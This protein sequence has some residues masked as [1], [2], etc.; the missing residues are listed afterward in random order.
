MNGSHPTHSTGRRAVHSSVALHRRPHLTATRAA[1]AAVLAALLAVVGMAG[2]MPASAAAAATVVP[3]VTS[4]SATPDAPEGGSELQPVVVVMDYSSSM[5]QADADEDGTTR[6]EAAEAATL[7]LIDK[8]PDGADLGVVVY[9]ANTVEDCVDIETVQSVAPLKKGDLKKKIEALNAVGET[10]I[11][12]SLLHAADELKDH[13]GEKSIILVSDGEENCSQPPACEAAQD[14]AD[15]GIDLTVHTI[16]FKVNDQARDELTCVAE[17]TGGTY[18]QAENAEELESRLE[19]K[20]VRAFQGYVPQGTPV[21]GGETLHASPQLA[22][23]QYL[24]EYEKGGSKIHAD[25]GT[26]KFY[27]LG[28]IQPGERAHFSA[29]LI[30]DQSA[31]AERGASY[32]GLKVELVNGQGVSCSSID[33]AYRGDDDGGRPIAGYVRSKDYAQESSDRCYSDGSGQLYAKVMRTS[34]RQSDLALP[35]ELK[36]VLEPAVD[37]STLDTPASEAEPVQSVTLSD[38]PQ[39]IAGGG[40]FN[41]ATEVDSGTVLTDSTMPMESRYYRI[42]VGYGQRL[43]VRASQANVDDAGPDGIHVD[44]YSA[45]RSPVRTVGDDL[46]YRS[47]TGETATQSMRVPVSQSNRDGSVG[48]D[49]YLAGDYYVVVSARKWT[50]DRNREPYPYDLA[51]E[52]TGEEQ[53]GPMVADPGLGQNPST[54]QDGQETQSPDDGT[55]QSAQPTESA[56]QESEAPVA[57]AGGDDAAAPGDGEPQAASSVRDSAPLPW[58]L[59]GLAGSALLGGV[60]VALL[61]RRGP[62]AAGGA[63]GVAHTGPTAPMGHPGDSRG[64]LIN[65][66]PQPPYPNSSPQN[67]YGQEGPQR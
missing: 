1:L 23:G 43:N 49:A 39:A 18:V 59:G 3:V 6:L 10:P 44:V 29:L 65:G 47:G 56:G 52:V 8:A 15:R 14:L 33:S 48:S 16:G 32:A 57:G 4:P 7:N 35:V 20:T 31:P 2:L 30:P 55:D 58:F 9:G 37:E 11:G 63:S 62:A 24:D 27:N 28:T 34:N 19:T 22:P 60:L 54:V 38:A 13:D 45:V 17:A 51:L 40:S 46:L 26:L 36:Y 41:D 5:L 64:T 25:D 53:D 50:G 66:Q 61:T 12:A 67:P 42:H 21:T